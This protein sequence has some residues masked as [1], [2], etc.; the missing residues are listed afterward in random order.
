MP[1][2]AAPVKKSTLRPPAKPQA[3]FEVRVGDRD[4]YF[5]T[6]LSRKGTQFRGLLN[7]E[8]AFVKYPVTGTIDAKGNFNLTVKS[9]YNDKLS[10]L[11]GAFTQPE[12]GRG[13]F[14][15]YIPKRKPALLELE[16]INPD[17]PDPFRLMGAHWQTRTL[18]CRFDLRYPQF[19]G[20]F[21]PPTLLMKWNFEIRE[22]LVSEAKRKKRDCRFN[23][24]ANTVLKTD[25]VVEKKTH[26]ELRLLVTRES[27][28]LENLYVQKTRL[29]FRLKEESLTTEDIPVKAPPF[30]GPADRSE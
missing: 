5:L 3:I 30:R 10:V 20:V 15:S 19:R 21:L 2:L 9:D 1:A 24:G 8:A 23:T 17:S 4:T 16:L 13:T 11:R 22:L 6:V 7:D 25:Y 27:D 26:E 14:E 29:I 12:L 28:L 18:H